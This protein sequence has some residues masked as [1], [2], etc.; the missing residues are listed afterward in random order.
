MGQ[1]HDSTLWN[2]FTRS[3]TWG[4]LFREFLEGLHH[5]EAYK[6]AHPERELPAPVYRALAS[7]LKVHACVRPQITNPAL[8]A[9]SAPPEAVNLIL[10]TVRRV[11]I[12]VPT[13]EHMGHA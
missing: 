3:M 12:D 4:G 8:Y 5:I 6:D 1:Q 11:M 9:Q 13:V 7:M 10:G 2:E